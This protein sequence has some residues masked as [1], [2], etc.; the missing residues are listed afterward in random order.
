MKKLVFETTDNF[1]PTILRIVLGVILFTHG[2]GAMLGWF[3]GHGFHATVEALN[4]Y[5]GLP[6]LVS[7]PVILIQFFGALMLIFGTATRIAGLC[8]FAIFIGMA[9]THIQ[10]GLHMNWL[11]TNAGEGYEYH[12]LVMAM[13][14]ALIMFGGGKFSVD[15][16]LSKP[17]RA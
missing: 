6:A 17:L 7:V 2:S 10:H 1:A 9:S 13:C 11:G 8:V 16:R 3:G 4:T 15:A 14:S 12:L 5:Y